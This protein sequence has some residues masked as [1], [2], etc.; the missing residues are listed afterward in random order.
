VIGLPERCG[1]VTSTNLTLTITVKANQS[2]LT[3]TAP[4]SA[5]YGHADATI[6]TNGGSGT[7]ALSF[8]AGTLDGLLDRQ[9][10]APRRV[11][12]RLPARSRPPRPATRTSTRRRPSRSPLTINKAN[13]ATLTITAPDVRRRTVMLTRRSP[14][15]VDRA[16][17]RNVV[18]CR[19]LA[20]LLDR[21]QASS[22]SCPAPAPARSRRPRPATA[23]YNPT[24]SIAFTVLDQ[25]GQPG[26]PDHHRA[27]LGDVR[28]KPIATITTNGG[29][30]TGALS[31]DAGTH[32]RPARSSS[33][34][35]HVVSGTGTCSITA[36]RPATRTSTRRTSVPFH[37]DDQQSQPGDADHHGSDVCDL[38]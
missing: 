4:T 38:R 16:R 28:R 27:D 7:G 22:T 10:Q 3:I 14:P 34:K 30:G 15:T 25:Q 37:R 29:S 21:Q 8:D 36:T 33:G 9:R 17:G 32:R 35:L 2:T 6:T 19:Q 18:R 20:G 11:R 1:I 12:H 24:T 26:D 5:T 23:T 31:F 13:Q